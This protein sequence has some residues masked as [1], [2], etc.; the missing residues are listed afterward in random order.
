MTT[1]Q[2]SPDADPTPPH[3][4]P[5]EAQPPRVAAVRD[6]DD[7]DALYCEQGRPRPTEETQCP[8]TQGEG[9][10][11]GSPIAP[12][13]SQGP[14]WHSGRLRLCVRIFDRIE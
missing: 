8:E 14:S 3:T 5:Q 4:A 11:P 12:V 1:P 9:G 13:G 7:G 10:K 6:D 2:S